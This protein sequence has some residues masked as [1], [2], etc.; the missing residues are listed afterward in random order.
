L[1]SP[2]HLLSK[3]YGLKL[4]L[5]IIPKFLFPFIVLNIST[6]DVAGFH[7]P[8]TDLGPGRFPIHL[9]H[10]DYI[11]LQLK[12]LSTLCLG[13]KAFLLVEAAKVAVEIKMSGGV[14]KREEV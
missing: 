9:D 8:Q 13:L 11:G 10:G 2:S 4:Q 12:P 14:A 5:F 3:F 7:C 6:R 1:G